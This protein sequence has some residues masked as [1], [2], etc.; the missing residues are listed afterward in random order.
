MDHLKIFVYLFTG[1][2]NNFFLILNRRRI[3]KITA[4]ISMA[5]EI[6]LVKKMVGLPFDIIKDRLKDI[7]ILSP[8]TNPKIRGTWEKSNLLNK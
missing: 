7:S 6:G 2:F 3:T 1:F 8:S 4:M 5:T